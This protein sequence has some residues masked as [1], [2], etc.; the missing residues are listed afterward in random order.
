VRQIPRASAAASPPP[1]HTR[2]PFQPMTMAVPVSWHI[3]NTPPAAM[4]AFFN[5][6]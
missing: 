4:L 3:G 5:R 2:W 1:V 6:S